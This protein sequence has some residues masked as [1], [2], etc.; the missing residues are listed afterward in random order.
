MTDDPNLFRGVMVPIKRHTIKVRG[1]RL[2]A[3]SIGQVEMRVVGVSLILDDILYVPG[4]G[5]N[6][7]SSRKLY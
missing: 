4:L 5:V 7:L 1:G 2:F 6:L 3:D